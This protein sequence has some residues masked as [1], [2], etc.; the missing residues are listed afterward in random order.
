M[1]QQFSLYLYHFKKILISGFIVHDMML[2]VLRNSDF[3]RIC[4]RYKCR[5]PFLNEEQQCHSAKR[6]NEGMIL[7]NEDGKED[8][9]AEVLPNL[10]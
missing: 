10:G 5:A 8:V 7:P 3:S 2:P 1:R 6:M 9:S 4:F